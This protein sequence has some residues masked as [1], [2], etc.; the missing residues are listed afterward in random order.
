MDDKDLVKAPTTMNMAE[1]IAEAKRDLSTHTTLKLN[2]KK[3]FDANLSQT[4]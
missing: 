4:Y 1:Q 2:K 3:S